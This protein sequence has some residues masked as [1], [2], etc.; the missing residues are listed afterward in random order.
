MGGELGD[1]T[2]RM[3]RA[4]LWLRKES[5]RASAL[6]NQCWS[7]G[8]SPEV[9]DGEGNDADVEVVSVR[10]R[11]GPD[12]ATAGNAGGPAGGVQDETEIVSVT[13]T[14]TA[15]IGSDAGAARAPADVT[16]INEVAPGRSD[17]NPV[18]APK[19]TR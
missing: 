4:A 17:D 9:G 8:F 10:R 6:E 2:E 7:R 1:S 11:I 19:A 14:P 16:E 18:N 12:D 5:G 3:E 13:G 15:G